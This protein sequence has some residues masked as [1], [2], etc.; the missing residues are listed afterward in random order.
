MKSV[1]PKNDVLARLGETISL[2]GDGVFTLTIGLSILGASFVCGIGGGVVFSQYPTAAGILAI[3]AVILFIVAGAICYRGFDKLW[4]LDQRDSANSSD[5][6]NIEL[7]DK[8][9]A[10][11]P[12]LPPTYLDRLAHTSK[13]VLR[14]V[15]VKN[16]SSATL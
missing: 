11:R 6:E 15:D 10:V 12:D 5:S 8:N 13:E 7:P 4:N 2:L 3:A 14:E 16:D 1:R 9:D